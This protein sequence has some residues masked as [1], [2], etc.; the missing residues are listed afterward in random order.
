MAENHLLKV[1]NCFTFNQSQKNSIHFI[2]EGNLWIADTYNN[3]T[4]QLVQTLI[5]LG[6]KHTAPNQLE[7]YGYDNQLRGL[8]APF[9]AYTSGEYNLIDILTEEDELIELLHYL[10]KHIFGVQNVIQG[11]A[12]S[13][14]QFRAAKKRPIESYK[15][16]VLNLNL[17]KL[18]DDTYA[19]LSHLFQ[20]GPRAGVTFVLIDHGGNANHLNFFGSMKNI[21]MLQAGENT[22]SIAAPD[23]STGS[24]HIHEKFPYRPYTAQ[25]II[26]ENQTEEKKQLHS[27][28]PLVTFNEVHPAYPFDDDM[29]LMEHIWC[30][31]IDDSLKMRSS[32]D[33][34]SFSLG[35]YG[36]DI[37]KVTIGDEINQRHNAL[38]TGAVGQG[39]SNLISV[40]IHSLSMRY[41]PQELELYL[42][43]FKEGVSLKAYSGID[44]DIYLP[45]AKAL[46]LESDVEYGLSMLQYLYAIYKKRMRLFKAHN[47]KSLKEYR[48]AYPKETMPRIVIII[49]EFQLMFGD[50]GPVSEQVANLLE[51]SVRLYRAAGI[52]FILAS[53]SIAGNVALM[54]SSDQ[55][56][57]QIPIRIAH[58]N[59]VAESQRTLGVGN[60][61]AATLKPREAIVNEDYGEE[62]QNRKIIAAYGDDRVLEP[63]RKVIWQK[64]KSFTE[65][66]RV[67]DSEKK[68]KI[69]HAKRELAW[70]Q[71]QPNHALIGREINVEATPATVHLYSEFGENILLLGSPN[72]EANHVLGIVEAL[73][74]S[75]VLNAS[76]DTS[77]S[78]Y[79]FQHSDPNKTSTFRRFIQKLQTLNARV[80]LKNP[81]HLLEG[82]EE[83]TK[84]H[85]DHQ[86]HYIFG[87]GMDRFSPKNIDLYTPP[88][89]EFMSEASIRGIHFIGWWTK[90]TNLAKHVGD[91]T[92][93]AKDFFNTRIFLN[94]DAQ[95][96]QNYTTLGTNWEA[97][98]NRVLVFDEIY[99]VVPKVIIP[100]T[101]LN[102]QEIETML[103]EE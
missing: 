44:N 27:E 49:D 72:R 33:G 65:P 10:K 52:H 97:M 102:A 93:K 26:R 88:L 35:K 30:E 54:G 9:S 43:D 20:A 55:I 38:I 68:I 96:V 62:S 87:I 2:G 7:V 37:L 100:Y 17:A 14:I 64:A 79:D 12:P 28:K 23:D 34:V 51:K 63:L 95:T 78:F 6:L 66:P 99:D 31:R 1:L 73:A 40:I 82:L 53:Q 85:E 25:E 103:G 21:Q 76:A 45:H 81:D 58:K 5:M 41:S 8:F 74:Y 91:M 98:D 59:S 48:E 50:E 83:I 90:G 3:Y 16:V 77:F 84:K 4:Q 69:N 61:A 71:N 15:L 11:Q 60:V 24:L 94:T 92:P 89:Q 18:E 57:S 39:K 22:V 56:F 75:L 13:L 86:K 29:R 36:D 101:P 46:A 80:A 42:L 70:V 67:F 19:L 47:V 32:I